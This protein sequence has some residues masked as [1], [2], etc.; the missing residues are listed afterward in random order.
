MIAFVSLFLGLV[1]GAR[2]VTVTASGP[3]AAVELLLDGAPVAR[4]EQKPWTALVDFGP[5]LSPHELVARALDARGHE[6]ARAR[7][8]LNLPRPAAEMSILLQRD[9]KGMATGA[10]LS[11]ASLQ[12]G[13]P[14]ALTVTFDGR[15][16]AV[17]GAESF[18][19]PSYD[20]ASTH[21]LSASAEFGN[22]VRCR[23]DAVLG[24]RT[25][26]EMG[27]ELTGVAVRLDPAAPLPDAAALEGWVVR[28]GEPLRAVGVERSGAQLLVVRDLSTA[29]AVSRL[30]RGG[31]TIIQAGR[32]GSLPVFDSEAL[33]L[34][35]RLGDDDRIRYIWPSVRSVATTSGAAE[36]FESS[37]EFRGRDSGLHWLLTRI[38]HPGSPDPGRRYADATAVAGLQA[39]QSCT[40]RAV[41]LVLGKKPVDAS[42]HSPAT[43]R[44][45]L[46]RVHVPL[47]VWSL[48][49]VSPGEVSAWG[50]VQDVSNLAKLRVAFERLKQ[51]L[52]SQAIVWVEG[53]H[54]PQ[55]I[56]LTDKAVGM[57]MVR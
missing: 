32:R 13:P 29:E 42:R 38:S 36:L 27:S 48:E 35:L 56:A 34:D 4:M 31:R 50:Q 26:I 25:A 11:W 28:R 15:R 12:P 3:V 5:E 49:P 7:Q 21:L 37:H 20:G 47:F 39:V 10:Q 40:R 9:E 19:L 52:E 46:G 2:P 24:G 51:E 16:L 23:A 54:L 55:E 44:A 45:Y 6:I 22:G 17:K 57:E 53:Q 33:R 18:P 1:I 14:A 8:W 41:L 43:V 30:G